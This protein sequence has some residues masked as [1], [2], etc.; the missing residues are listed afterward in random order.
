MLIKDEQ[1]E[2]GYKMGLSKEPSKE[3][4]HVL[5]FLLVLIEDQHQTDKEKE[6]KDGLEML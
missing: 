4:N 1:F 5:V 6:V 3:A 2:D